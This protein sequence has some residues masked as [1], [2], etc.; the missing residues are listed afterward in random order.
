MKKEIIIKILDSLDSD[1]KLITKEEL[2]LTEE[3]YGEILDIMA[4]SVLISGVTVNRVGM[5]GKFLIQNKH[6]QITINGIEYLER[7]KYKND[8]IIE[9][10]RSVSDAIYYLV[11]DGLKRM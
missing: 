6:P 7:S 2:N 1:S 5:E 11:N 9:A 4:K 8:D 3:Q 10:L